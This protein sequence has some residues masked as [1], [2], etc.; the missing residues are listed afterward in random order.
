MSDF[1][2][3]YGNGQAAQQYKRIEPKFTSEFQDLTLKIM[4]ENYIRY[5]LLQPSKIQDRDFSNMKLTWRCIAKELG[6]LYDYPYSMDMF[7]HSHPM[8]VKAVRTAKQLVGF[9]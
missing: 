9:E 1:E 6:V 7:V 3:C 5:E 8:A 2:K 4:V